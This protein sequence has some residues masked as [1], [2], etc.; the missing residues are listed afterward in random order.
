MSRFARQSPRLKWNK[1]TQLAAEPL[2]ASVG[3]LWTLTTIRTWTSR[4]SRD[5]PGLSWEE[6]E[7]AHEKWHN[8]LI[9]KFLYVLILDR[10][11]DFVVNQVVA[12]RS[13]LRFH[14][15]PLEMIR[16]DF[17]I[18]QKPA[19]D[20]QRCRQSGKGDAWEVCHTG[21]LGMKYEVTVHSD[22][23]AAGGEKEVL[24]GIVDAAVSRLGDWDGDFALPQR[25]VYPR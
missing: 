2:G 15:I 7:I 12:L 6:S 5:I 23:V 4:D 11:S 3:V 17:P 25:R 22:F 1:R 24:R 18:G 14:A 21:L 9:F 16:Q 20:T 13:T 19:T 8:G 10:F